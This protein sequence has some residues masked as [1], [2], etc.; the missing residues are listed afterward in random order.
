MGTPRRRATA[1][2][3]AGTAAAAIV[4]V[5]S[6]SA[7]AH[8]GVSAP[9]PGPSD[10]VPQHGQTQ[11]LHTGGPTGSELWVWSFDD[12]QSLVQRAHR[13]KFGV[14]LVWVSPGFSADPA[15]MAK[16]H[17]LLHVAS[18][19]HVAVYALGGDPSWAQQPSRAGQ[20]AAEVARTH[21]FT[22][23]HLDIEPHALPNWNADKLTLSR[24]LLS[25]LDAVGDAGLR[26]EADIPTWYNTVV[27][28]G[29][30]LDQAVLRRVDGITVM[31][32]HNSV[33]GVLAAARAEI[34]DAAALRRYAYIGVNIADPGPDG[35]SAS[36][37][38]QDPSNIAGDIRRI[39]QLASSWG[40]YRGIAVHDSAYLARL[41]PHEGMTFG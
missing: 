36:F 15:T 21:M 24:G 39:N 35:A 20:W 28:D 27:V 5:A 40:G 1:R 25:A 12:P 9:G 26:T 31:A 18:T 38:G 8:G 37:L 19:R 10:G 7:S 32:Y 30:P 14:L 3:S 33:G 13:A 4:L 22:A 6:A 29:V 23:L 41:D 11:L 2:A 17:Q 34:R 16:L